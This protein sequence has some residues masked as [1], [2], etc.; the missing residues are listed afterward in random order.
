MKRLFSICICVAL[1]MFIAVPSI[2]ETTLK[3]LQDAGVVRLGFAN[4]A[5][6]SYALPDGSL[7]GIDFDLMKLVFAEL[8]VPK[9]EG[10]LTPFGS[11]MP[12]SR[13]AI[14]GFRVQVPG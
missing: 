6:Y 11:L 13:S 5:P 7:A 12:V 1:S 2:A 10:V 14:N 8:G 9:V 4:E 3:Q